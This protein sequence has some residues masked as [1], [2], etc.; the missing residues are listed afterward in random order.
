MN[1][2]LHD[3]WNFISTNQTNVI[4]WTIV[5]VAILL[6]LLL[7]TG[8]KKEKTRKVKGIPQN[9]ELEKVM[10]S[11]RQSADFTEVFV[12]EQRAKVGEQ[13]LACQDTQDDQYNVVAY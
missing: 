6:I 2:I 4:I 13:E 9:L 8:K 12:A 7:L 5:I 11:L 3:V 10:D 1:K